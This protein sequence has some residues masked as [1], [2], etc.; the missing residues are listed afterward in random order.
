[1]VEEIY[2]KYLA[3]SGDGQCEFRTDKGNP[4][5]SCTFWLMRMGLM[6]NKG[7]YHADD[8]CGVCV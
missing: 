2:V 5:H 6:S 4:G 3:V 1:M 8:N 7:M